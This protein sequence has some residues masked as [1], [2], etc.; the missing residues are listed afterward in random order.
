MFYTRDRSSVA[1]LAMSSRPTERAT[2]I[3]SRCFLSLRLPAR[4]RY[5]CEQLTVLA[6]ALHARKGATA[7]SAI[8]S[9]Q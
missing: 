2:H 7:A 3:K 1:L 6:C 4:P 8:S 5:E 9:E